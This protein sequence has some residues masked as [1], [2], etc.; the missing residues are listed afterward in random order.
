VSSSALFFGGGSTTPQQRDGG[1]DPVQRIFFFRDMKVLNASAA[2]TSN[3]VAAHFR[4]I[5][6]VRGW[7]TLSAAN[8]KPKPDEECLKRFWMVLC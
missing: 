4:E 1:V 3:G 5:V 8:L 6:A 2:A 7:A